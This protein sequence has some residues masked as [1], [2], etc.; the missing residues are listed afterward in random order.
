MKHEILR[1]TRIRRQRCISPLIGLALILSLSFSSPALAQSLVKG[2]VTDEAGNPVDFDRRWR[3][4][5]PV[6]DADG[7]ILTDQAGV[8]VWTSRVAPELGDQQ[9]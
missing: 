5:V 8:P 3:D 4:Q 7:Q 6:Y 1:T 9:D 2:T